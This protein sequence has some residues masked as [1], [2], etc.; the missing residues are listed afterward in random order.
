MVTGALGEPSRFPAWGMPSRS[1]LTAPAVEFAL[2]PFWRPCCL[3]PPEVTA[4]TTAITAAAATTTPSRMYSRR[5]RW[6]AWVVCWAS[7]SRCARA[8]SLSSLRL[9]ISPGVLHDRG[10]GW[11]NPPEIGG[12]NGDA[13]PFDRLSDRRWRGKD[14][15]RT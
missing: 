15:S 6:S 8:W 2:V 12:W 7:A 14:A 13:A 4:T 10:L 1:A 3:E 5:L 9:A 11:L